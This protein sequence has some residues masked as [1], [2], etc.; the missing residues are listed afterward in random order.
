MGR[1]DLL[2]DNLEA[3]GS[4]VLDSPVV[5]RLFCACFLT[6]SSQNNSYRLLF[7]A[8]PRKT[9]SIAA[10]YY[11]FSFHANCF[12]TSVPTLFQL[13]AFFDYNI[14]PR[15]ICKFISLFSLLV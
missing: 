14:Y 9:E 13:E 5:L 6:C 4:L 10:S 3:A 15:L 12:C 11:G 2:D 8:R 1:L 7:D